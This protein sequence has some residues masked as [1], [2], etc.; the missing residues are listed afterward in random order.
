[1]TYIPVRI[2]FVDPG[3]QCTR[4]ADNGRQHGF[5]TDTATILLDETTGKEHPFGPTCTQYVISDK[6]LLRGI[7]D[8]TTR[9]F[10]LE[11]GDGDGGTGGGAGGNSYMVKA[12]DSEKALAFAKRY[13]MLRMDRVA[14][15]PGI[16]SGIQYQPLARIYA[17][18]LQT[19]ELSENDVNHI[20]NLEKSQATPEIYRSNNLLDVYTAHV[21]LQRFIKRTSPGGYRDFLISVRDNSLLKWLTLSQAQIKKAKLKLHP[22]AFEI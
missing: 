18:F 15:I 4:I 5:K 21:Q 9:D 14:K 2:D 19:R 8:F 3:T 10:T 16:Q 11:A 1:M 20:I 7:P 12:T 13:I 6:S 17:Q 22:R